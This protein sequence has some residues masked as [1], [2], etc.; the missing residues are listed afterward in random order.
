MPFLLS[1][2]PTASQISSQKLRYLPNLREPKVILSE[3]MENLQNAINELGK[4][5]V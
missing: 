1:Y 4:V 3:I 2:S 5:Y